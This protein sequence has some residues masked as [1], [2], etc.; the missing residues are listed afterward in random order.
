ME[1]V[2]L[3]WG[4]PQEEA[5]FAIE[6]SPGEQGTCVGSMWSGWFF[7]EED[8]RGKRRLLLKDLQVSKELE[9]KPQREEARRVV[10]SVES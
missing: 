4:R 8:L 9:E 7:F 1:R 10:K 6:R 2:V 3:L 5:T